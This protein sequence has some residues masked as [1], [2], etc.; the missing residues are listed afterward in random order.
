MK[1]S[2]IYK[3]Q[4]LMNLFNEI[5]H[6]IRNELDLNVYLLKS[7]H[8]AN[9]LYYFIHLHVQCLFKISRCNTFYMIV[10]LYQWVINAR[11]MF[12]ETK[13]EI[14]L[15]CSFDDVTTCFDQFILYNLYIQCVFENKNGI[16]L[17]CITTLYQIIINAR[18]MFLRHLIYNLNT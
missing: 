15:Y 12:K 8:D 10:Y 11:M 4:N 18:M 14:I 2:C 3:P 7:R 1:S 5:Q 17:T 13:F 6:I 9:N 16:R